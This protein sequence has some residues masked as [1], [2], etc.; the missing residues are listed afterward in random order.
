MTTTITARIDVTLLRGQNNREHHRVRAARVAAERKATLAAL[1]DADQAD[2]GDVEHARH[3]PG[4]AARVTLVRPYQVTPL[5]SDNL[6]ASF[7]APRDAIAEFLGLDDASDRLHWVY[8]QE[9]AVVLGKSTKPG[10]SRASPDRD[11]RPTVTIEVLPVDRIDPQAEALAQAEAREFALGVQ[12]VA[13]AAR[14]RLAEAVVDAA[15]TVT[16]SESLDTWRAFRD[17]LAA[18]DA[19]PGDV[20]PVDL[21]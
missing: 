1:W 6:S 3:E 13:Q 21:G 15:R 12:V 2:F 20:G 16:E 8:R 11:T 14:L 17:A 10:K 5:D 4:F 18:W 9:P 19:V 7:K